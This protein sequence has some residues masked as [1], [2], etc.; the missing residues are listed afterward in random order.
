MTSQI[1]PPQD[2]IQVA[3]LPRKLHLSRKTY[4]LLSLNEELIGGGGETGPSFVHFLLKIILR[5]HRSVEVRLNSDQDSTALVVSRGIRLLNGSWS[6]YQGR[7]KIGQIK[8]LKYLGRI[9]Y[10]VYGPQGQEIGSI[11]PTSE[12]GSWQMSSANGRRTAD[13]ERLVFT[14]KSALGNFRYQWNFKKAAWNESERTLLLAA[15]FMI[16]FDYLEASWLW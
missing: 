8:E 9:R 14:E 2:G 1:I 13:L 6:V 11:A 4:A 5:N 3:C 12:A 16:D 10:G 7:L 15:C